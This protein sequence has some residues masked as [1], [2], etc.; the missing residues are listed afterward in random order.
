MTS[1]H[2]VSKLDAINDTKSR[3]ELRSSWDHVGTKSGPSIIQITYPK[4]STML[5]E[6]PW[7]SNLHIL[8]TTTMADEREFYLR[9]NSDLNYFVLK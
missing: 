2:Q 9:I 4:L 6:L 5:R 3:P 8:S 7:S 1:Q